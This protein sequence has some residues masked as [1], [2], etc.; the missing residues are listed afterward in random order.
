MDAVTSIRPTVGARA[1][2]AALGVPRATYY[3]R[4]KPAATPRQR[5]VSHRALSSQEHK[6]ILAVLHEPR[7]VDLAVPQIYAQLLEDGRYLCAERTMY[8][9]LEREKEVSDR[10]NQARH[11]RAKV[12]RLRAFAPRQVWS[13]D[14]TKI[15]GPF[16]HM[17][18]HLYVVLD[19]FSRFV[20]GWMLAHRESAALARRLIE[21]TCQREGIVADQLTLHADRGPAMK[22]KTLKELLGDLGIDK[23]HSRPR[24]SDDNP[25]SEAQFKTIKYRPDALEHAESVYHGRSHFRDMFHWYN[26]E[27]RHS[28]LAM[29]T[30]AMVHFDRVDDVIADKQVALDAALRRHPERFPHG[31][32]KVL[33]PPAEVW[34]NR[35][36]VGTATVNDSGAG[37]AGDRAPEQP[38]IVLPGRSVPISTEVVQ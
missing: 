17:W 30:P 32:P 2:C 26:H 16:K 13:W 18:F 12:P 24:V 34:I 31:P 8:R 37:R 7:F 19:I 33:R 15:P 23:S 29:L 36:S 14:I 11:P 9:I 6:E 20:V 28:G 4:M 5:P 25:Y 38:D 10:R 27:H 3:R 35:P 1:A 22:S 21:T